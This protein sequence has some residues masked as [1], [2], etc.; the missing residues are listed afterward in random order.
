MKYI[1]QK[2]HQYRWTKLL[3]VLEQVQKDGTNAEESAIE[4]IM[5][6]HWAMDRFYNKSK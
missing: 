4:T 1:M 6:Y 3:M 5:N 2:Y